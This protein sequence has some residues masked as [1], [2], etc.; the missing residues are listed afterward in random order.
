LHI[1][2]KKNVELLTKEEFKKLQR[3]AVIGADLN[4]KYG[5]AYSLWIWNVKRKFNKTNEIWI[6]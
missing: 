1:T 3:V 4:S 2:L 6:S 5:V